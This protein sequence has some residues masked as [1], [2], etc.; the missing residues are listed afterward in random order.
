MK[1]LVISDAHSL[2][3]AQGMLRYA[4]RYWKNKLGWEI[5]IFQPRGLPSDHS[6]LTEAGMSPISQL[7][8]SLPYHVVLVNSFLNIHYL[9]QFKNAPLI[10]W[11]HEARTVLWGSQIPL[12]TLMSL[13]AIPNVTIFSN[14]LSVKLRFS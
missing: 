13:F 10:F 11:V 14:T 1:I 2:D 3:G 4:T 7:S 5:D 6:I 8:E 9:N 12:S